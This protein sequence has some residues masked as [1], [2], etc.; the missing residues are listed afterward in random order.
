MQ[1]FEYYNLNLKTEFLTCLGNMYSEK[2]QDYI[3][4]I[5][6]CI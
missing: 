2:Q 5:R 6:E 1:L 3:L 4:R